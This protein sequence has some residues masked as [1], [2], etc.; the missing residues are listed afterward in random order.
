MLGGS[1]GG[2][3]ND[4]LRDNGDQINLFRKFFY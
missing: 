3:R 4:S 1:E 2:R